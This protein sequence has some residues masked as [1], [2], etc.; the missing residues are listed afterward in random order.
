[1]NPESIN[2]VFALSDCFVAILFELLMAGLMALVYQSDV[3][4][5]LRRGFGEQEKMA[6]ISGNRRKMLSV[7]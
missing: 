1:M 7:I 3:Q 5:G 6:F 4:E 2:S